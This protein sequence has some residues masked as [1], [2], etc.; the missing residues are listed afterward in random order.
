MFKRL[1]AVPDLGSPEARVETTM[2]EQVEKSN[3][4]VEKTQQ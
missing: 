4:R 2:T 1:R 3:F